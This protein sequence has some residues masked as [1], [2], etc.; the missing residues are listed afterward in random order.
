MRRHVLIESLFWTAFATAILGNPAAAAPSP[1]P[2]SNAAPQGDLKKFQPRYPKTA[3]HAQ[4]V[5]EVNARG[6]VSGV[7]SGTHSQ[8]PRFDIVTHG[9]VVQT[10]IRR[11]DGKAIS[12]LYRV[13]YDYDP[14]TQLVKRSVALLHAGGVNAKAPGLVDAFAQASQ[15]SN[16]KAQAAQKQPGR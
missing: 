6:Q 16:L 15:S 4:Y 8:D 11:G 10:F 1:G 9:N 2:A 13:S 14:R 7:R 3:Q 5:V 12:G